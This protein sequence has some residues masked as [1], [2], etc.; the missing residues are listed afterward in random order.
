MIDAAIAVGV[1]RFMPH[2]FGQDSMNT[3]VQERIPPNAVRARL[4]DRLRCAH[5]TSTLLEWV[6]VAVG[7]ILDSMLASGDIGFDL[8]WQ[9]ATI[10]GSG[11]EHFAATSLRRVGIVTASIIRNWNKVK[12]QYL[13]A[14]SALTSA[15][16]V[17]A[18]LERSTGS[19][20]SAGY[21]GVDDCVK[22]GRSRIERG[23]P[24]AGMLLMERS[25]LYDESL[26]AMRVF[27]DQDAKG[28]L[29]LEPEN[30]DSIVREALHS[31]GHRGQLGCGCV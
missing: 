1:R 7:C 25:I 16:E 22:E 15:K 31:F 12:N 4:V 24:D 6:A 20:W 14:A 28:I 17:V 30:V 8:Q 18:C 19:T 29:Q 10:H 27:Q 5:G 23:F 3:G 2:E 26:D 9:S 21:S 11:S 13:Y